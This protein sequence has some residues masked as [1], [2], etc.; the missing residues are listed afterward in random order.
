[1]GDPER[2]RTIFEGIIDTHPKRLDL[3]NIYI[4]MEAGQNDIQRIRGICER[5]ITL[6]LSKKKA[7]FLFKKWL[8]LER[9]LG[10]EQGAEF[11]KQKA[12]EWTQNATQE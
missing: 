5:A 4:D 2:G 8:D 9:R 10:D 12:V 3:W 1:M 11:V 7:K 6:K